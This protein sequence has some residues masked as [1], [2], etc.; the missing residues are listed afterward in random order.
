M[1]PNLP[2]SWKTDKNIQC[3]LNAIYILKRGKFWA[4]T[5]LSAPFI[6]YSFFDFNFLLFIFRRQNDENVTLETI[7]HDPQET[8]YGHFLDDYKSEQCLMREKKDDGG[9]MFMCSCTGEEC[10]DMLIFTSGR[11]NNLPCLPTFL[12]S[13]IYCVNSAVLMSF[14]I[15]FCWG[16]LLMA[17]AILVFFESCKIAAFIFCVLRVLFPAR[18]SL[19]WSLILSWRYCT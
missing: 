16:E 2:H 13:N 14:G 12:A 9:L 11:F 8:L 6:K 15:A 5:V 7:C 1:V 19:F 4:G 18:L 3:S 17:G 10:N